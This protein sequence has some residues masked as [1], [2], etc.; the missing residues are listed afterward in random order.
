MAELAAGDA[1]GQTIIADGNCVVLEVVGKVILA[2]GHGANK[3]TDA[4]LGIKSL[5]VILDTD[6]RTLETQRDFSTERR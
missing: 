4:L 3:D 1:G 2:L 6:D 5:D